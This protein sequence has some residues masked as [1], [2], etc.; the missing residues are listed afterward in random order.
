MLGLASKY[1]HIHYW[2]LFEKFSDDP[3]KFAAEAE[4]L[5]VKT[6]IAPMFETFDTENLKID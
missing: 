3:H 6:Y 4:K 2:G 5:G 1:A